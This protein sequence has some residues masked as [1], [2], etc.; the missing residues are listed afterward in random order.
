MSEIEVII[1]TFL[2][3]IVTGIPFSIAL[4]VHWHIEARPFKHKTSLNL[5]A[6][7]GGCLPSWI[8]WVTTTAI[9]GDKY[10]PVSWPGVLISMMA[11]ILGH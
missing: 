3:G 8:I 1:L 5:L 2:S 9:I 11:G 10:D 4:S 7:I 6:G